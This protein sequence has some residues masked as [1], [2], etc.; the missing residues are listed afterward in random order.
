M[1][2]RLPTE[3]EEMEQELSGYISKLE[4]LEGTEQKAI[5]IEKIKRLSKKL[6]KAQLKLLSKSYKSG[7]H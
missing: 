3:L 2:P 7:K 4:T 1:T 6:N 5:I